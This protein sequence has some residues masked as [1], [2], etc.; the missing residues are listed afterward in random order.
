M[1][2]IAQLQAEIEQIKSRNKRVEL[3]KKR[4]T[5][6]ARKLWI[7]I[8]TYV[9][10]GGYMYFLGQQRWY[11]DAIVPTVWFVLWWM[12]IK[13]AKNIWIRNHK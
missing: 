8:I 7:A 11:L 1:D 4:E 12:W 6:V 13:R 5:S 10:L 9:L 2:T 3:E